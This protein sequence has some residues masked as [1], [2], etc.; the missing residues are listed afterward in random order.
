MYGTM[1]AD[2]Y[3]APKEIYN[4]LHKLHNEFIS[5]YVRL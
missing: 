1:Y 3:K 2:S 5:I 4:G